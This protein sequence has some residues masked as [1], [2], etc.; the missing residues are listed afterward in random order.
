MSEFN[1]INDFASS[2]QARN[3]EFG[4]AEG[5]NNFRLGLPAGNFHFCY[6]IYLFI[7]ILFF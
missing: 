6:F 7:P 2:G 3:F 4:G 1:E 5:T